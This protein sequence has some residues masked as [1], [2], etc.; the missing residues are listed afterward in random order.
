MTYDELVE[1]M[2]RGIEGNMIYVV[3]RQEA[4]AFAQ[5]A[6]TALQKDNVVIPRSVLSEYRS[7][8][9]QALGAHGIALTERGEAARTAMIQAGEIRP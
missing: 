9:E 7:Q 8:V 4:K 6:L 3:K 2:A 5:A 1:A